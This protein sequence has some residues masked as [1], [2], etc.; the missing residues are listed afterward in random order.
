MP[1][2]STGLESTW[3]TS[4]QPAD[5]PQVRSGKVP[6]KFEHVEHGIVPLPTLASGAQQMP[7]AKHTGTADLPT[8]EDARII[9]LGFRILRDSISRGN[10]RGR[11]PPRPSLKTYIAPCT[12]RE[13]GGMRWQRY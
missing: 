2:L 13:K 7:D 11:S 6:E 9:P 4:T 12:Q 10:L 8:G 1:S 3:I 5:P